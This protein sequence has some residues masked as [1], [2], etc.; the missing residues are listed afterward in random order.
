MPTLVVNEF[1]RTIELPAWE[2]TIHVVLT[3]DV[4]Q[5]MK[6]IED[7]HAGSSPVQDFS[8]LGNPEA[9]HLSFAGDNDNSWIIFSRNP[10]AGTI[11]H[12]SWH[13][14]RRLMRVVGAELENETVAYHLGY[15]VNRIVKDIKES[16]EKTD[17]KKR[18][19]PSTRSSK[20][21]GKSSIKPRS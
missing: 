21:R 3:S 8:V 11:A 7:A 6:R 13:A 17:N 5:S 19:E 18:V 1:R 10:S 12:E 20:R 14:V 9:M 15:I 16:N 4:S 2:Y